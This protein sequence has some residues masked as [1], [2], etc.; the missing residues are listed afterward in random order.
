ME[1]TKQQ[2]M[3]VPPEGEEQRKKCDVKNFTKL[4]NGKQPIVRHHTWEEGDIVFAKMRGFPL[5]PAKVG[6]FFNS[7][8]LFKKF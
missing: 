3:S 7:N 6:N 8:I 5:W 2:E 4:G 1:N